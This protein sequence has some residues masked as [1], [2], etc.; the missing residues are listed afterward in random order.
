MTPLDSQLLTFVDQLGQSDKQL[1]LTFARF[2]ASKSVE[3]TRPDEIMH[4][5]GTISPED[6]ALMN[7]IIDEECERIDE[8]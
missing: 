4:L 3:G 7:Q 1:V 5:A 8:S 2:L 6:V